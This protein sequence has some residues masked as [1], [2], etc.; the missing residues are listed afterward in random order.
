MRGGVYTCSGVR[1][2]VWIFTQ[3]FRPVHLLFFATCTIKHACAVART[4]ECT[5][6]AHAQIFDSDFDCANS[7]KSVQ[8][9]TQSTQVASICKRHIWTNAHTGARTHT[10]TAMALAS[11]GCSPSRSTTLQV[12]PPS[13]PTESDAPV[14]VCAIGVYGDSNERI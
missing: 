6:I 1:A 5:H 10:R 3:F 12:P 8:S 11:R 14:S 2:G 9:F 4:N 7:S 13:P